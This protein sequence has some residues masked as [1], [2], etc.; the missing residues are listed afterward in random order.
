MKQGITWIRGIG[1]AFIGA[2]CVSAQ[3]ATNPAA[4]VQRTLAV[5]APEPSAVL[6]TSLAV[7]GVSAIAWRLRSRII[8]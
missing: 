3:V 4:Q 8:G 5:V 1:L 6:L 7:V 2:S